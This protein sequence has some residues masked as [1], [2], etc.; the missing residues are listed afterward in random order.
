[1]N[2]E[3]V[4]LG[5]HDSPNIAKI[6]NEEVFFVGSGLGERRCTRAQNFSVSLY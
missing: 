5:Q 4:K 1:V 3:F 6:S 2:H